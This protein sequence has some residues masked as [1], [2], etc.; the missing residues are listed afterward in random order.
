MAGNT[1]TRFSIVEDI[2]RFLGRIGVPLH[3]SLYTTYLRSVKM[4]QDLEKMFWWSRMKKNITNF[5]VKC[6]I[7]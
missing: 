2:L 7:Y 5:M 6:F 1:E 4:Y 3:N